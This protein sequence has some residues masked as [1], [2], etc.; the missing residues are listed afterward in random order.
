MGCSPIVFD[1]PHTFNDSSGSPSIPMSI[2]GE[3]EHYFT[4]GLK[5][6]YL[7]NY[8]EEDP[9]SDNN[10]DTQ[11]SDLSLIASYP[12][13]LIDCLKY[14]LTDKPM[15]LEEGLANKFCS[16]KRIYIKHCK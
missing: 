8:L 7:T 10:P 6:K 4:V 15:I 1:S 16:R 5:E 13:K 2:D 12:I 9:L 11:L 14:K 3:I